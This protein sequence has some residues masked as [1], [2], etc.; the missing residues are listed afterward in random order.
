MRLDSI[1]RELRV[2]TIVAGS[3][4]RSKGR[5]RVA[6]RLIDPTDGRQLHSH[7]VERAWGDLFVLQDSIAADIASFLREGLG[8]EVRLRQR[9]AGTTSVAAWEFVQRADQ[10]REDAEALRR[11]GDSRATSSVAP[12]A[13]S[14]YAVA[15]SLD[16]R[17]IV[18]IVGRARLALTQV[19]AATMEEISRGAAQD[20]LRTTSSPSGPVGAWIT[21][22]LAHA[23]RALAIEPGA[24]DALAVRGAL[25]SELWSNWGGP[26]TLIEAAERDL[27][28]AVDSDPEFAAAWYA[29]SDIYMYTVRFAEADQAARRAL[30]ADAYLSEAWGVM[31]HLFFLALNGE[32]FDDARYWCDRGRQRFPD[33]RNFIDCELRILGWSGKGRSQ[34]ARA[35]ELLTSIEQRKPDTSFW[36]DRRMMVAATLARTNLSDS[37]RAVIHRTRRALTNQPWLAN[38]MAFAEA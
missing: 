5:L 6:V 11:A 30:D 18:P 23:D 32:R 35:W 29:L 22:G 3:V 7:T 8:Q 34:V 2:G 24:P 16:D 13:D 15:T 36:A 9:R 25:R 28:A 27:R 31:S 21:R 33:E 17:W 37:A 14:L 38:D 12:R 1:A 20:P 19:Q 10:L 26:D 4:A